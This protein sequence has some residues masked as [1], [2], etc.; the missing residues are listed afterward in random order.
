MY[1]KAIDD[2]EYVLSRDPENATAIAGIEEIR[3]PVLVLPMLNME[4]IDGLV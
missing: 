2:Y 3:Q 1:S 4:E